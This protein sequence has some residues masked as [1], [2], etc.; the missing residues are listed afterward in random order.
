MPEEDI[1]EI[2]NKY[3]AKVEEHIDIATE[4][5]VASEELKQFSSEYNKFREEILSKRLTKY[6][7]WC[8]YG[9]CW[10]F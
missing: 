8:N 4:G 9:Q 6:E 3:R 2:I 10:T 5:E 7:K 1:K